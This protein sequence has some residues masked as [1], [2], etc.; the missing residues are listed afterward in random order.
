MHIVARDGLPKVIRTVIE[1][2]EL[3][4]YFFADEHGR[5]NTTMSIPFEKYTMS[6]HSPIAKFEIIDDKNIIR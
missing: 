4:K 6:F 3:N 2:K 1:I 5:I